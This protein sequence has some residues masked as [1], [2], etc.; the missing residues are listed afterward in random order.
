MLSHG[1]QADRRLYGA[2]KRDLLGRLTGTVVEI[3]A[4]AGPNARYLAPGTRWIAVEPNVH[5]HRHLRR[6]AEAR[7]L[8]LEIIGT[9]AERLPLED[10]STEA[11]LCTLVL[12]SVD[13][14]AGTLAEIRRVLKPGGQFV[15][16]EHVA[17]EAG[18]GLRR[19]QRWMRGPWGLVADGCCP[20]RETLAAIQAAGFA[21]VEA[22]QFRLRAG[23]VAPH[24]AGI[25]VR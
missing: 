16:I 23:L 13:D 22:E 12:C 17:A 15:F 24:I 20:D 19:L 6:A 3:G 7:G 4:G 25:A 8:E 2:R 21:S 11:V 9:V 1:E 5:F 14:V 10:A 18:S